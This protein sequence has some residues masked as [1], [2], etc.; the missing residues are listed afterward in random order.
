V[1]NSEAIKHLEETRRL[2]VG[3]WTK[4]TDARMDNGLAVG[5]GSE[6]AT[7]Y[8]IRGAL[9]RATGKYDAENTGAFYFIVMATGLTGHPA[10]ALEELVL[11]NDAKDRAARDVLKAVDLA[12]L[13]AREDARLNAGRKVAA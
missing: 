10:Y 1:S 12:L 3:G 6:R 9:R 11:W 2:L 5:I 8:C 4:G 13:L 7:C